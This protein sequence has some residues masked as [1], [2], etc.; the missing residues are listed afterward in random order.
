MDAI[1]VYHTDHSPEAEATYREI[2]RRRAIGMT[3]GSDFHGEGT[4]RNTVGAVTLPAAAFEQLI[5]L[6]ARRSA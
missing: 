3:G 4:K 6:H 1:E 5:Q 2:A